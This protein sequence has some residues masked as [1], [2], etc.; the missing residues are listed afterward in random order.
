MSELDDA[1]HSLNVDN[2]VASTA[3]ENAYKE[4]YRTLTSVQKDM[5]KQIKTQV[6]GILESTKNLTIF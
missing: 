6:D 5:F 2:K 4:S 3:I 1:I